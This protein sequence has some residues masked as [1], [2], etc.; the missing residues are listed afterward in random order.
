MNS[1]VFFGHRD[2]F[3]YPQYKDELKIVLRM[4]VKK[5]NVTRFFAGGRGAFDQFCSNAVHELKQEFPYIEMCLFLSYIPTKKENFVLPASYDS[6]VYVLDN[7]TPPKFAIL[8]TNQKMIDN[9]TFV[10]SGVCYHWGGAYTAISYAE[11]K[12]R[13]I[14]PFGQFMI[15]KEQ[16]KETALIDL[17]NQINRL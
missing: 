9:C 1:C 6:S 4:L 2:Y 5:Y 11:K 14:I 17:L 16:H 10:L 8:K 13:R 12:K 3:D 15:K 7:P